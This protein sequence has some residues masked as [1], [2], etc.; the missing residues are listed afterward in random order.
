M[1]TMK[2][3]GRIILT[4]IVLLTA[5]GV[6]TAQEGVVNW[7]RY[8]VNIT[9]QENSGILVEE[10]HDVTLVG[11]ATTFRRVIPTD[12]VDTINVTEVIALNSGGGQRAYQL[13]D[14]GEDYTYQ[15]LSEG[16]E[17]IIQLHFP[18]NNAPQSRFFIKYFVVGGI[19]FYEDGNQLVW[20]PFGNEA[21]APIASSNTVVKLPAKLSDSQVVR[22]STGVATEKYFSEG[23]EVVFIT[24]N[25]P[26]HSGLEISVRFPLGMVQGSPPNWQRF[27]ELSNT[28]AW[29]SVGIGFVL[30][31]FS[32]LVVFIWWF[33]RVRVS[34]GST[35]K[36]PKY[37]KSPPG[38]LS[39]AAAGA[40]LD[41]KANARHIT[42]TLVDLAYRGALN[43][44][45]VTNE[46]QEQDFCFYRV[47]L[48]QAVRP[49]ERTLFGKLFGP[50]EKSQLLANRKSLYLLVPQLK[51]Q[52][53]L[54]LSQADYVPQNRAIIR[55]QYLAF[56]AAGVIFS[57]ILGLLAV[58]IL[59]QYTYL[60]ICPFLGLA[61][62]GGALIIVGFSA[63]SHTETGLQ[64]SLRWEPF[65]RYLKDITKKE[66]SK[67]PQ[68]FA[69]LLP[70]AV[71]FGLEKSLAQ[72]FASVNAPIPSWW[73]K[74][75]EKLP[76]PNQ[77]QAHR[78]LSETDMSSLQQ[79]PQGTL[80]KLSSSAETEPPATLL[81]HILP[82]FQA[83]LDAELAVFGKAPPIKAGEE[84]DLTSFA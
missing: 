52:I 83:F 14:T 53:D 32:P 59:N 39:P 62:G 41:G 74:P 1:T 31:L 46:D 65:R 4:V 63:P 28:L 69:E 54:E 57:L 37:I 34:V 35:P 78:W 21:T 40:L 76:D 50:R 3:I 2:L 80:R 9:I 51:D 36:I 67:Y 47:A 18:P 72:K 56:G 81:K 20:Q 7:S 82:P 77:D 26:V 19:G 16:N 64:Q 6:A 15:I 33:F 55:R 27:D 5:Y 11:G 10:V 48:D 24:R 73:G 25:V 61:V 22:E 8:D 44:E 23:D 60:A 43:V 29:V 70:Y 17:Q 71:A 12:N 49:Y 75:E 68:R 66:A 84:P 42:A 45:P 13:A 30:L 38:K 79:K 58:V